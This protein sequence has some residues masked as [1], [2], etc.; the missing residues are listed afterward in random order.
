ME[1]KTMGRSVLASA[2]AVALSACGGGGGGS[3]VRIDPPPTTP[4]VTPP[5]TPP[6]ASKPLEPAVDAHLAQTNARAAQVTGATG[7]GVRIGIVDSGVLRNA[8]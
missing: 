2:L 7:R 5:V 4:P 1:R 8:E 3:N 6:P